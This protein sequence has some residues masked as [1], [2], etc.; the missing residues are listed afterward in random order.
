MTNVDTN[1][2]SYEGTN[3]FLINQ[4][5]STKKSLKLTSS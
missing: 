1:T 3:Y 5:E 2:L 4:S